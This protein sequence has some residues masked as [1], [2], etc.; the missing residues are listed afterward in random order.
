LAAAVAFF[1]LPAGLVTGDFELCPESGREF[2]GV[3][4]KK[5]PDIRVNLIEKVAGAVTK[6]D[7]V[8]GCGAAKFPG[9]AM[10]KRLPETAVP[11]RENERSDPVMIGL[12]QVI[13]GQF[14]YAE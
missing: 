7:V 14:L 12:T 9:G 3:I 4:G 2:C 11:N 13:D 5:S 6:P 1:L 8:N 10:G